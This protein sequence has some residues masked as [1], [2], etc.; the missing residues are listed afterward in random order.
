[1]GVV[2]HAH[3][4]CGESHIQRNSDG[5]VATTSPPFYNKLHWSHV[6]FVKA[7]PGMTFTSWSQ[8]YFYAI[9][10][11]EQQVRKA[12]TL[13]QQATIEITCHDYSIIAC[14]HHVYMGVVLCAHPVRG[15]S[16]IK[17][18]ASGQIATVWC[19]SKCTHYC[20]KTWLLIYVL[21]LIFLKTSFIINK[22]YVSCSSL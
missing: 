17:C 12:F 13:W 9:G 10:K 15:E 19:S 21:P 22:S 16:H 11:P 6:L 8:H 5:H 7:A 18:N 20:S 2:L 14:S 3:P 4:V 1:M